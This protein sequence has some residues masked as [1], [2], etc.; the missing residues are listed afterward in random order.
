MATMEVTGRDG[1]LTVAMIKCKDAQEVDR[2]LAKLAKLSTRYY[3]VSDAD[4]MWVKVTVNKSQLGDL[5][6]ADWSFAP[7]F[8]FARSASGDWEVAGAWADLKGCDGQQI[9]VTRRDGTK[10][11]GW[12]MDPYECADGTGRATFSKH[13]PPK[14]N[15]ESAEQVQGLDMIKGWCP[16][17]EAAFPA[18]GQIIN[19]QR[20]VRVRSQFIPNEFGSLGGSPEYNSGWLWWAWTRPDAHSAAA[21]CAPSTGGD[22]LAPELD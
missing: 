3:R 4:P 14:D 17:H 13:A 7:V 15:G 6:A 16:P 10:Q 8:T 12:A 1:A 11:T 20:V 2:A 5:R 18:V 19:G 22:L 9:T 21:P